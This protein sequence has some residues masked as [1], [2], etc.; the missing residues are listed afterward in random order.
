MDLGS[1]IFQCVAF[2]SVLL[3]SH[4][5]KVILHTV[6][7]HSLSRALKRAEKTIRDPTPPRFLPS[8]PTS[9]ASGGAYLCLHVPT[10]MQGRWVRNGQR[11]DGSRHC[12]RWVGKRTQRSAPCGH[13]TIKA[14]A[15]IAHQKQSK[16]RGLTW[17]GSVAIVIASTKTSHLHNSALTLAVGRSRKSCGLKCLT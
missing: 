10:T 6:A 11:K 7:V 5:V 13:T 9:D 1:F 2:T 15:S 3:T 14:S 8:G 4:L 12:A 16:S 17:P